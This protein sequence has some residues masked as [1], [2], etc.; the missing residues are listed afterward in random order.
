MGPAHAVSF[1]HAGGGPADPDGGRRTQDDCK[2]AN[3]RK[4]AIDSGLVDP[5]GAFAHIEVLDP[6]APEHER[7][8]ANELWGAALAR[9]RRANL[10]S[11]DR[12]TATALSKWEKLLQLL[13]ALRR[14][15]KLRFEGDYGT[16]ESNEA[17]F[18]VMAEYTRRL[19]K[20]AAGDVV[21]GDTVSGYVS[22]IKLMAEEFYGRKL[23]CDTGGLMLRREM[24]NMRREDG[25]GGQRKYSAPLRQEHLVQLATGECGFDVRSGGWPTNRWSLMQGMHQCMM[26]GGEPG[27]PD[28]ALFTPARGITWAHVEW[29]DPVT[30]AQATV[31]MPDT[32]ETHLLVTIWVLPIK[33]QTGRSKRF[34]IPIA[35]KRPA[36]AG[37]S[38]LACPFAA[39]RRA[40]DE[41]VGR[42]PWA[43]LRDAPFFVGPDGVKAVTTE[44]VRELVIR[45]AARCLGL[46][47][48][49][50]GASALRRGAATD[51]KKALGSAEAKA[52][53]TQRGRWASEDIGDIYSRASLEEHATM[54]AALV[55]TGAYRT[56]EE[57]H[58]GWVQPTHWARG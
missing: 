2:A 27:R 6:G 23:V 39:L 55:A 16:S 45:P 51:I 9:T 32:G 28:D 11:K 40:W 12:R 8:L 42:A 5:L 7:I 25:P 43:A 26:R 29:L 17:I 4:R 44:Q 38:D 48:A 35:S 30:G 33:D 41:R 57:A 34:P 58:K 18:M 20:N 15:E 10:G 21:K 46:V 52:L 1:G 3:N 31:V 36:A 13:P 54:S 19:P 22:A 50:F 53:I 47:A 24:Q 37:L 14:P 56:M 49:E